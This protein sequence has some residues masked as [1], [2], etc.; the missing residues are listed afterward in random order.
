M[1]APLVRLP[2]A[3]P[4]L[5]LAFATLGVTAVALAPPALLR[6]WAPRWRDAA[7]S[8][9]A[10]HCDVDRLR[11]RALL[12]T[13]AGITSAARF[14]PSFSCGRNMTGI[15]LYAVRPASLLARLGLRNGDK[16]LRVNGVSLTSPETAMHLYA[17]LKT[18][19]FVVLDVQRDGRPLALTY[20]IR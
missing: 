18:A 2:V 8:C 16:L 17:M 10:H 19:H 6:P 3:R 13:P 20:T 7:I 5:L 9:R 12:E 11:V 4:L 1:V 14:L 15:R